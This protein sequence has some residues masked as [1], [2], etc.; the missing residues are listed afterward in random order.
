VGEKDL[1][2]WRPISRRIVSFFILLFVGDGKKK[3]VKLIELLLSVS[4][5]IRGERAYRTF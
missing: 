3:K 2:F 5:K 1:L 4:G